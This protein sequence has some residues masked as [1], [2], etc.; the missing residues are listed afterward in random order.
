[1][2]YYTATYGERYPTDLTNEVWELLESYVPAAKR[3]G[4]PKTHSPREFP[5]AVFYVLKRVS[6]E[7]RVK[8][9]F[10]WMMT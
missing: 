3:R 5:S 7:N 10:S 1:M 6:L 8:R 9:N 2:R 4:R